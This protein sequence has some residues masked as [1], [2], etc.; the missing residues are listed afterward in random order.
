MRTKEKTAMGQFGRIRAISDLPS[1]KTLLSYIKEAVRLNDAGIKPPP[2]ANGK[3]QLII[4]PFF[5]TALKKNPKA[6]ATFE[7]FSY[8]HKKEYVQWVTEAKREETR[9]KRLATTLQWLGEGRTHRW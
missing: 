3:R 7:N 8:S 1:K 5:T 9:N 2:R 6:L 4:P